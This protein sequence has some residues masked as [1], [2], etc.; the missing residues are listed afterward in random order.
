M[1][2]LL[3]V[4]RTIILS[5]PLDSFVR[6]NHRDKVS[7]ERGMNPVSMTLINTRKK[8]VE[9]VIESVAAFSQVLY[10]TD[11]TKGSQPFIKTNQTC[12]RGQ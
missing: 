2:L 4:F 3:P 7:R 10:A 12:A 9:Q 6:N 8:L 11:S 1:E 5:K